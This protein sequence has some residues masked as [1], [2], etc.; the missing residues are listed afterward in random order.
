MVGRASNA[1]RCKRGQ[2]RGPILH[3]QPRNRAPTEIVPIER[4]GWRHIEIRVVEQVGE[5][6]AIYS[7]R[8]RKCSTSVHGLSRVMPDP[9]VDRR[10]AWP[11]VEGNNRIVS[12]NPTH[13]SDTTKIEDRDR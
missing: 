8:S 7:P 10:I 13:I 6:G 11:R 4:L 1:V 12:A 5:K 9:I 2:G 3:A